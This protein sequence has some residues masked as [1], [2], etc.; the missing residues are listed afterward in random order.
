MLVQDNDITI[1][2]TKPLDIQKIG[3]L[4]TDR[5]RKR[6]NT[7]LDISLLVI[8]LFVGFIVNSIIIK[9]SPK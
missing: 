9:Q 6:Y 8:D 1:L 4:V 2:C 5:I 3:A 7:R